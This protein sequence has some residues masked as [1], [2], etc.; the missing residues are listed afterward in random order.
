MHHDP[1]YLVTGIDIAGHLTEQSIYMVKSLRC[2]NQ[3]NMMVTAGQKRVQEQ[4]IYVAFKTPGIKLHRKFITQHNSTGQSII[5][6]IH[7]THT[8]SNSH[9]LRHRY[10]ILIR[11]SQGYIRDNMYLLGNPLITV[12]I[13]NFLVIIP[14][15]QRYD[16]VYCR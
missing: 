14:L 10:K 15:I 16:P 4:R 2:I 7:G 12:K 8:I 1:P 6:F 9:D 11:D 3:A 13:K 5:L